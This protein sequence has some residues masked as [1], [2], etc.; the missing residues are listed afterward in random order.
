MNSQQPS[1]EPS[2]LPEA[3]DLRALARPVW[4]WKWVVLLIVVVAAAGTYALTS[5]L[6]KH[7]TASTR[8]YV[9]VVDPAADVNSTQPTALP[10]AQN[11]QDL[12]TLFTAEAITTT[13]N[14]RLGLSGASSAAGSVSVAALEGANQTPTSFLV[15]TASARSGSLAAKIANAYVSAFLAAR[16]AAQ[17]LEASSDAKATAQELYAL[18]NTPANA[19]Q[20]QAL[21]TQESQLRTL[22]LNPS[23]GA[24]QTN[25]AVA[26]SAP[27]SPDPKRDTVIAAFIALLLA[28]GVVFGLELLDRRLVTVASVESLYGVPAL[29]VLPH[30]RKPTLMRDDYAAVPPEFVEPLRSLRVSLGLALRGKPHRTLLVGSGVP[31]EG[32][33]TVVRDLALVCAEA[34][35]SVLIIDADL[36]RPSIARVLGVDPSPEESSSAGS[37]VGVQVGLAQVLRGE[38]AMADAVFP[39]LQFGFEQPVTNGARPAR[40]KKDERPG[41]SNWSLL[42]RKAS[43]ASASVSGQRPGGSLDLMSFGECVANP[44]GLLAS[45]AMSDV[46]SAAAAQY[47]TVLV[48][49]AP[50]LAVADSVP[51]LTLVDGVLLVARLGLSTRE[52][53][54]RLR[55]LLRRV[56]TASVL[57]VVSNDLRGAYLDEAYGTYNYGYGAPVGRPGDAAHAPFVPADHR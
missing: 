21:L 56:P 53:S 54:G 39:V 44:V 48:D 51:L 1:I 19:V 35:E 9:S 28:I 2:N 4:R 55:T 26:P 31:G 36:R 25:P 5:H 20:R 34:G 40:A 11:M 14:K 16:R 33:S 29:A 23:A 10:T 22:A 49:S 45:P 32:K 43:P 27:S 37:P 15:V 41:D 8:V 50:F 42:G 30:T 17:A 6:A 52:S 13:V 57:G 12:A 24:Q 46:L 7:Y 18:P 38:V 47:D 3:V